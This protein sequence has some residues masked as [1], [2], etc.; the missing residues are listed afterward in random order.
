LTIRLLGLAMKKRSPRSMTQWRAPSTGRRRLLHACLLLLENARHYG[1]GDISVS[2][3][4]AKTPQ[5]SV[6][7]IATEARCTGRCARER[8]NEPSSRLPATPGNKPV[9]WAWG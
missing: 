7:D 1:S 3:G 4:T 6:S 8:I 2:V 9:A 5:A